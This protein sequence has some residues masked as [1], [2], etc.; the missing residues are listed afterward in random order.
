M[1]PEEMFSIS[2]AMTLSSGVFI[3][4]SLPLGGGTYKEI[5][6]SDAFSAI[7]NAV[8]LVLLPYIVIVH[9]CVIVKVVLTET[10]QCNTLR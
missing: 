5:R 1:N 9:N 7:V 8:V 3:L 4:L 2:G 10:F 6:R